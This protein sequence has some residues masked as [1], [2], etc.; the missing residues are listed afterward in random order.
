ME[1]ALNEKLRSMFD[2]NHFVNIVSIARKSFRFQA[3]LTIKLVPGFMTIIYL[4]N[5]KINFRS[6]VK[7]EAH[8]GDDNTGLIIQGSKENNGKNWFSNK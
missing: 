4:L 7:S 6:N 2:A 8:H 5:T 1:I 3:M